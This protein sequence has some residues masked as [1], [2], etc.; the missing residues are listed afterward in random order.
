MCAVIKKKLNSSDHLI[1]C[2]RTNLKLSFDIWLIELSK[3][4]NKREK[5]SSPIK[6]SWKKH[7]IFFLLLFIT[8]FDGFDPF[9]FDMKDYTI[10]I[11]V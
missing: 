3:P 10:A 9:H 7:G 1:I 8:L 4:Q 2:S 11:S 6:Q 5:K